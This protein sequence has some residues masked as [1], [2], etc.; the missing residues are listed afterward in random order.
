MCFM[1]LADCFLLQ[2][3][4]SIG[5]AAEI[6]KHCWGR[7]VSKGQIPKSV[8]QLWKVSSSRFYHHVFIFTF[9]S[10][11]KLDKLMIFYFREG[12]F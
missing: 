3:G 8:D 4:E 2:D 10:L 12:G 5:A 1:K 11:L 7:A 9:L 6:R